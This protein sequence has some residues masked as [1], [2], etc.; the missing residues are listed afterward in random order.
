MNQSSFYDDDDD[1]ENKI[2]YTFSPKSPSIQDTSQT[3]YPW[4]VKHKEEEEEEGEE[5]SYEG[6]SNNEEGIRKVEEQ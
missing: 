4:N 1:D 3:K 2:K 5:E 6:K